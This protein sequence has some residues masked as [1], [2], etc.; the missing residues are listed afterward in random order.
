M[1]KE[2]VVNFKDPK[3]TKE[4]NLIENNRINK[5]EYFNNFSLE[6]TKLSV[7]KR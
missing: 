6:F 5:D 7:I 4:L 2:S 1:V 3:L